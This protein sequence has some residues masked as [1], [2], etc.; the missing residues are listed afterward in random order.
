MVLFSYLASM[1]LYVST[2]HTSF[3]MNSHYLLVI[4]FQVEIGIEFSEN[5]NIK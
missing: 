1:L 3:C 2:Y 5:G 4:E